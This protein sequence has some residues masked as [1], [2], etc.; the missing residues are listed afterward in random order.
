MKSLKPVNYPD[1]VILDKSRLIYCR[2]DGSQNPA[3]YNVPIYFPN[4]DV[5]H[6]KTIKGI[7]VKTV[8]NE[9]T[10]SQ[11]VL[12]DAGYIGTLIDSFDL[13]Y[14]TITVVGKNGQVILSDCPLMEF[15]Y[16]ITA[17]KIR[18]TSMMIDLSK[19]YIR[20]FGLAGVTKKSVI[21]I[22][23]YYS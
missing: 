12:T 21:P 19:S 20:N 3:S 7:E 11:N 8:N 2:F 10:G 14:F 5:L 18:R 6:G 4:D 17:G 16:N 15:N 9:S 23:F 13:K 22:Q 1:P